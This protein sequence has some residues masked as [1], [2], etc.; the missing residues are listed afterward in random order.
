MP[1]F[2]KSSL[3]KLD[4]IHATL[5]KV[6]EAAILVMDFSVIEGHRG[7]QAQEAA[8]KAGASKKP[9]PESKHNTMP[10]IA[11]DIAPYPLDWADWQAFYFLAGVMFACA[12]HY[13]VRL[14]W[15]GDW[16]LNMDFKDQ[17]F[18]DLPH[19]ELVLDDPGPVVKST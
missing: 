2:G 3:E 12:K 4:S 16:N 14:R 13:G 18:D 6:L 7:K 8:L 9:W 19:F 5:R 17:K 1:T 10:S 15:G 11:V